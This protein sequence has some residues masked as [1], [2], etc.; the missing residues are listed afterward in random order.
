MSRVIIV[1]Y[2]LHACKD[3]RTG[4]GLLIGAASADFNA[5]DNGDGNARRSARHDPVVTTGNRFARLD[6]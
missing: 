2:I 6:F 4:Y 3:N 5:D 1:D